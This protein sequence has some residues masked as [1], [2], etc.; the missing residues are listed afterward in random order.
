MYISIN[1]PE[2]LNAK[3]YNTNHYWEGGELGVE[4]AEGLRIFIPVPHI[5][6]VD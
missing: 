1:E 3:G 5:E 2:K 6:T 4:E